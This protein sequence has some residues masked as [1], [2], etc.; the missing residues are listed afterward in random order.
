MIKTIR[1]EH[2]KANTLDLEFCREIERRL[3]E[4]EDA[5]AVILTG[6]GSIF[7][8]GVDLVRLTNEGAPYVE[9]FLPALTSM[10]RTLFTFPRPVV[11]AVNGHAIAGGCV[12]AAACD[13]RL[14]AAGDG[15]IGMPELVVGVPFPGMILEIC[16]YAFPQPALQQMIYRGLTMKAD[17]ALRRGVVDEVVEAGA[18]ESRAMAVAEELAAHDPT[19]FT[20][21]KRQLRDAAIARADLL[22]R[23]HDGLVDAQW[24]RP[25]TH[26]R[27]REY[28][29]RTVGK[30]KG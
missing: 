26:Q 3:R 16:R 21:T 7:S 15:R 2:G 17:E 5:S 6:T 4:S 11:A 13:A 1:L 19:N 30:R 29:A 25:E 12:I 24:S 22:A 14:M 23:D 10:L 20:L 9:Q 18:L 28:L 8:A 27:I